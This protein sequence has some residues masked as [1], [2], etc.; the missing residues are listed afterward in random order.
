MVLGLAFHISLYSNF[1]II[2]RKKITSNSRSV[3]I[4]ICFSSYNEELARSYSYLG[5]ENIQ[6]FLCAT[7]PKQVRTTNED[8][9]YIQM[10]QG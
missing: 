7:A 6:A 9:I 1:S 4:S 10:L 2:E 3:S 8:F 5:I